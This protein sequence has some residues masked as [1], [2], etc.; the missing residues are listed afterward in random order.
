[1]PGRQSSGLGTRRLDQCLSRLWALI[2]GL[3]LLSEMSLV[4]VRGGG[5]ISREMGFVFMD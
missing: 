2:S 5:L 1:M 3:L 4:G